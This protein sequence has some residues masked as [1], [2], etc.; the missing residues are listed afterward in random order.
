MKPYLIISFGMLIYAFAATGFLVPHKIVGG[1]ATG[2]ATVLFYLFKIPVG[3]GYFLVNIGTEIRYQNHFRYHCRECV[4]GYYA[5]LDAC[6]RY[7]TRRE[8]Y[9]YHYRCNADRYRY[10]RIALCWWKYRRYGYHCDVGD[11]IPQCQSGAG[12]DGM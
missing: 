10:R 12:I 8:I 4:P 11:Q 5:A 3:I 9:E 6:G 2:I 1:G 7:F